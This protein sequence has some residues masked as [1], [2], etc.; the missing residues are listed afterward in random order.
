MAGLYTMHSI[1][2]HS[3]CKGCQVTMLG[4][5]LPNSNAMELPLFF[6]NTSTSSWN[7]S[8][9]S[10]D[11]HEYM[12]NRHFVNNYL[13]ELIFNNIQGLHHLPC[14]NCV[15]DTKPP[16]ANDYGVKFH[17]YHDPQ[18]GNSLCTVMYSVTM[19]INSRVYLITVHNKLTTTMKLIIDT[20]LLPQSFN[21]P[22][23]Y[24]GFINNRQPTVIFHE[25]EHPVRK[26]S[27]SSSQ[28]NLIEW[29]WV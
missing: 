2:Q 29:I 4:L 8:T 5:Y 23:K 22:S 19:V 1:V 24:A 21:K 15:T 10:T 9:N 12:N 26:H 25:Q 16:T 6:T 27:M 7:P 13:W 11:M 20:L 28:V 17:T 3:I 18:L 14:G